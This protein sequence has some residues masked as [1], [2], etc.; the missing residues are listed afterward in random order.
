MFSGD[1]YKGFTDHGKKLPVPAPNLIPLYV[2]GV[3]LL[4]VMS[5][6]VLL[7]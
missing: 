2:A 5:L 4:L 1:Q 6:F 7:G 3:G